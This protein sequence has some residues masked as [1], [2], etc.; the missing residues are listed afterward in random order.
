MRRARRRTC[1]RRRSSSTTGSSRES[2]NRWPSLA[3]DLGRA[4]TTS[5]RR[6][7]RPASTTRPSCGRAPPGRTLY[8]PLI[9]RAA[10]L[11]RAPATPDPDRYAQRYAHCDVLV[12]GAGPAGLAAALAAADA[13]AR[14]ILCDEQAELGGSLLDGGPAHDRRRAG[15]RLARADGRR[16]RGPPARA[17]AAR[18]RRRSATSRTTC[19]ALTERLTDHLAEPPAAARA[20][21]CGRCGRARSC[22]R[23]ARSSS[24]SCFP[25]TTGRA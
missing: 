18:A 3:F 8:E 16:A 9:R 1:A 13:G 23:P 24:R 14:V 25:A 4:R 5:S 19:S 22:W 10:G 17:A 2:Q 21:G 11:G 20:S 6:C 12:V 7:F 15:R